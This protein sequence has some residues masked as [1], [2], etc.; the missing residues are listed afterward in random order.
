MEPDE[1][2]LPFFHGARPGGTAILEERGKPLPGKR[3][4]TDGW[5]GFEAPGRRGDPNVPVLQLRR[6]PF[7]QRE[8]GEKGE[9]PEF[10]FIVFQVLVK[11]SIRPSARISR[12]DIVP[13]R[14]GQAGAADGT[15]FFQI[16]Q[17]GRRHSEPLTACPGSRRLPE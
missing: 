8:F 1:N 15:D 10:A 4:Q 9:F 16:L 13:S 5:I 17:R 7:Q 2:G 11:G 14:S 3:F 12:H 6:D